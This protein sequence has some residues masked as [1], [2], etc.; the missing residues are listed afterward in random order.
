MLFR[1]LGAAEAGANR[2]ASLCPRS[3]PLPPPWQS[4]SEQRHRRS[5]QHSER[6]HARV[7]AAHSITKH[8]RPC[9]HAHID[10]PVPARAHGHARAR[11]RT[12]TPVP[13]RAHRHARA[14]TRAHT[15]PCP[16][17]HIDTPTRKRA[18]GAGSRCRLPLASP[19]FAPLASPPFALLR[20]A[21]PCHTRPANGPKP[22]RLLYQIQLPARAARAPPRSSRHSEARPL[23]V[24]RASGTGSAA[25]PRRAAA[26]HRLSC[27]L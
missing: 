8:T 13:A 25:S 6:I 22:S 9:P 14:R 18:H 11:T 16:H 15:R 19:P 21:R 23:S 26:E 5:T 17:A 12:H 7:I 2:W 1:S 27:R 3:C 24:P 10:T 4:L 20:S